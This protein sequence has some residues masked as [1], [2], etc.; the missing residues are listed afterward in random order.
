M[1]PP[2]IINEALKKGVNL[3][4]VTDHNASANIQ[5]IQKA[6]QGTGIT[7]LP[8]MELQTKEDIHSICL[9]DTLDQ[10]NHLQSIVDKQLP[11]MQNNIDFFG[12]QFVVDETGDFIRREE[13]LLITSTNLSLNETWQIVSDLQ[14]ILIPAHVDRKAFGLL[15]VLGFVP[16]DI[17]LEALEI[18]HQITPE[19]AK[20][21]YPELNN[22]PLIAS[23]DAHQLESISG[24]TYFKMQTPSIA[25]IKLAFKEIDKRSLRID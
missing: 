12:E 1:V 15:P 20:M 5:A 14:G 25:E 8:G 16:K 21:R 13:R 18:S 19:K 3:L 17:P 7:I 24:A 4:A 11:N 6:A 2:L 22:Y 10:V 9:F 23:G